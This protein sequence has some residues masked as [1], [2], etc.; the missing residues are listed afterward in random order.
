MFIIF[1]FNNYILTVTAVNPA[2][3]VSL[4]HKQLKTPKSQKW[5]ILRNHISQKS[6][7]V[8]YLKN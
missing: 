8:K 5:V 3:H 2:M 4:K 7:F 1:Y 6:V